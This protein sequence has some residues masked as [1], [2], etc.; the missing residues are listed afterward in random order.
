M[1]SEEWK[2]CMRKA[3]LT[4]KKN[5]INSII[6]CTIIYGQ[7]LM[8]TQDF[9]VW[10]WLIVKRKQQRQQNVLWS[11][12]NLKIYDSIRV[13]KVRERRKKMAKHE[14][15]YANELKE[16]KMWK[17]KTHSLGSHWWW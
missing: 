4:E 16:E 3:Q 14:Y 7:F 10:C 15:G 11:N 5:N 8:L 12:L 2:Q 17:V 13:K 9:A 6:L 1:A